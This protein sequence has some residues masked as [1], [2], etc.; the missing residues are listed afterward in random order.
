MAYNFCS[1]GCL[2]GDGFYDGDNG[3]SGM[4]ID[5]DMN[6]QACRVIYFD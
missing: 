1:D 2:Y 3:I 4:T 6:Y 5:N